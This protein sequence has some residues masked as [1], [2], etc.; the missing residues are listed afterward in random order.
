MPS[1]R[2]GRSPSEHAPTGLAEADPLIRS[3]TRTRRALGFTLLAA[4]FLAVALSRPVHVEGDRIDQHLWL[5]AWQQGSV[6]FTNSVTGAPVVIEFGLLTGID[7]QRML[8][9][10]KTENYYTS[11]TYDLNQRLLG[12]RTRQLRYCSIVGIDVAIASHRYA[13]ADSCLEITLLWPPF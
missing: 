3:P 1:V 8:T 4:A 13:L 7:R 11:G 10:E 6:T 5:W 9:D 12:K 2:S